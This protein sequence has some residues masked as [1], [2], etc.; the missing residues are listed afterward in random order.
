MKAP[1]CVGDGGLPALLRRELLSG[2]VPPE[3]SSLVFTLDSSLSG[4]PGRLMGKNLEIQQ[5]SG[6][7]ASLQSFVNSC[8]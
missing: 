5:I 7:H 6:P 3:S 1:S 4:S 8:S 2:L